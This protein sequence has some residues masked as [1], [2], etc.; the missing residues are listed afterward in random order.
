MKI[1]ILDYSFSILPGK[2]SV[3]LYHVTLGI[4]FPPPASQ[5]SLTSC[6]SLK[7]PTIPEEMSRS[8]PSPGSDTLMYLGAAEIGKKQKW[9]RMDFKTWL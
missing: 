1:A 4:G 8:A 5:S 6:P 7:G 9:L 3:P 2:T